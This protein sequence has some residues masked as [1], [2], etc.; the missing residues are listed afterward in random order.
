[1]IQDEINQVLG[2]G[3]MVYRLLNDHVSFN[4]QNFFFLSPSEYTI[5]CNQKV[6]SNSFSFKWS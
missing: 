2:S 5:S 3:A 4:V 1:M 6:L